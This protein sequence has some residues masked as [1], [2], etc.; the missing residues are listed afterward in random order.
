M[1]HIKSSPEAVIKRLES[2]VFMV[3][4]GTLEG[5]EVEA[6]IDDEKLMF[7]HRLDAFARPSKQQALAILAKLNAYY[8]ELHE[9]SERF[10]IFI[11]S[12][13][14]EAEL[15][16]FS[17]QMDFSVATMSK[18]GILWHVDLDDETKP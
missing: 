11:G 7:H 8:A 3:T 17:G 9:S 1:E 5:I 16:V 10:R 14:F 13:R 2:S 6:T 12:R 18:N 4:L 15:Y